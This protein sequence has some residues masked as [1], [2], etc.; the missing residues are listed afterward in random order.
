M[1]PPAGFA[2]TDPE[3]DEVLRFETEQG[4]HLSVSTFDPG[5]NSIYQ[6]YVDAKSSWPEGAIASPPSYKPPHAG[7]LACGY[8]ID[9]TRSMVRFVVRSGVGYRIEIG[10]G[11]VTR[12]EVVRSYFLGWR[13][14]KE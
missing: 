8:S 9:S 3:G 12:P 2:A 1:A 6:W 11:T 7:E 14:M 10:E 5:G 13:W 4:I